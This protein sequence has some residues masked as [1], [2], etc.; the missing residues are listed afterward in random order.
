MC[1]VASTIRQPILAVLGAGAATDEETAVAERVGE[2]AVAH[3]WVVLTGGGPGVMA[4]ASRGAVEAGGTTIGV[5]PTGAPS[6]AYPNQWVQIAIYTDAGMARNAFNIL[7]A[8]LCVVIGGGAGTLSE[9]A[10]A[11]KAGVEVWCHR[12]WKIEP[13]RPQP[14][15]PRVIDDEPTFLAELEQALKRRP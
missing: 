8:T 15:M 11:L 5:L 10:M 7:S 2:M 4:A 13:S 14:A 12:S 3:G 9:I 1:F 6:D